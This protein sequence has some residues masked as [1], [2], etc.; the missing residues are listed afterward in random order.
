MGA[1]QSI[2]ESVF[3]MLLRKVAFSW[4]PKRSRNKKR[5]LASALQCCDNLLI[6]RYRGGHSFPSGTKDKRV[7]KGSIITNP[8]SPL[9]VSARLADIGERALFSKGPE[10]R[11]LFQNQR[12]VP[13]RIHLQQVRLLECVLTLQYRF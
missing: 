11:K 12:G 2:T 5:H 1:L 10:S 4:G 7:R 13:L 8:H 9:S 6:L 3:A